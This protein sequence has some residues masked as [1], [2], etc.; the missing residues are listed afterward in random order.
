MQPEAG[1]APKT[2]AVMCR[3][4]RGFIEALVGANRI[5]SDVLLLNTSFACPALAEV[6]DP[7][8]AKLDDATMTELNAKVDAQGLLADQVASDW[9]KSQGF[10]K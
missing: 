1:A 8:A 3:N 4:H 10:I 7:V 9:L 5:G 2:I 6:V